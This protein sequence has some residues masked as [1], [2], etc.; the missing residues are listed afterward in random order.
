MEKM[1]LLMR[2]NLLMSFEKRLG[3][4]IIHRPV[5]I[6]S[7]K[8]FESFIE[9]H[10][11]PVP[12]IGPYAQFKVMEL[13]SKHVKVTLD[14]QGADEQLAGYHYFF[15]SYYIELLKQFKLM[16]FIKENAQYF[17]K[18]K[19]FMGLKYF[20]YYLLPIQFQKMLRNKSFPSIYRDFFERYNNR[21]EINKML[22]NPKSLTE[23][24]LQHFEFKLEHLLHWEDLNSMNFSIE[25]RVPFLDYQLVE[26]TLSTPSDQKIYQG[27]TK[28]LLRQALMDILPEKISNRKDKKGYSNPREK[29]FKSEKFQKYI[30][31]LI[32]SDSFKNRGYFDSA[33]ANSQYQRHLEGKIDC[34]KEI[35]KWINLEI[36][37]RKFIDNN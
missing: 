13:A 1:S 30:L 14:G 37:F 7:I 6:L 24:L 25:A 5:Q 29:W 15:G 21:Q 4:C 8:Y 32:N 2:V 10:N 33:I 35:W 20:G 17:Q 23:S 9:A 11:E 22:Y 16:K 36:W 18:H 26:A 12:D 31:E 27:E 34:S 3:I 28:H 19:S